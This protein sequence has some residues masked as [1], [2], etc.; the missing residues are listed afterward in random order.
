MTPFGHTNKVTRIPY[1]SNQ[2]EC[3][4]EGKKTKDKLHV[5]D[6]FINDL[7]MQLAP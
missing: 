4:I 3:F 2:H 6:A 7:S 5:K 1:R